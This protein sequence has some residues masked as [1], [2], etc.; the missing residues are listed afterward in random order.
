MKK[1]KIIIVLALLIVI[2]VVLISL[3]FYG[4]T[5]VSNNTNNI[6]FIVD[7]GSSKIDIIDNLK[8][9]GLIKS[10]ISGYIY[11][12]F[13]RN[14]NL[15]AGEYELNEAM[16]LKE[17]LNQINEGKIK[18]EKNTFTITFVEGKRIPYY[19]SIIA[20]HTNTTEEEVLEI[21]S[22]KEYL[23]ELINQYWFLTDDI[24]NNQIYYPLEGYLFA[25][26]YEF[27]NGSSVKDIVKKM[28]D[29]MD[30]AL[31]P[32]KEEIASSNYSIHEIITL[33]SIV[34]VEGSNSD[35]RAGVAGVFYNRLNAGWSLGSDATTYYGAKIDFSDRDLYQ[36]E[37]DEV[38]GYNTRVASMAGKLPVGP[39]CSPSKESLESTIKPIEHDNYYFVADINQKTYFTKT[40]EEHVAKVREL[41][42]AGLWFTY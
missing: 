11:V 9:A 42:N 37:I 34:E 18:E 33:A 15:Q 27:Y 26:T 1:K 40:Y 4:L 31:T 2:L 23:N 5:P 14:L 21:L 19:A 8:E 30:Q 7:N 10:K 32:Y 29:G 22:D 17:I 24:L 39:I 12:V 41:Q 13:H 25:S 3:Y 36:N 20:D 35:D 16:S 28:L 6:S 38:N